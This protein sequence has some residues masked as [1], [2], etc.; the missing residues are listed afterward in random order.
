VAR[1]SKGSIA[2]MP[3]T[4]MA[5][6]SIRSCSGFRSQSLNT[7]FRIHGG[8]ST[9]Q[10]EV[11]VENLNISKRTAAETDKWDAWK[12][13]MVGGLFVTCLDFRNRHEGC[14]S[15]CGPLQQKRYLE[16]CSKTR[17]IIPSPCSCH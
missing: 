4:S 6:R 10:I 5:A 12:N 14:G 3:K 8:I 17:D 2:H 7:S 13:V 1:I 9:V 11:T 16:T 15:A